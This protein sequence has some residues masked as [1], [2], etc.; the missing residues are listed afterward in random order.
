MTGSIA[1]FIA[2]AVICGISRKDIANQQQ[3]KQKKQKEKKMEQVKKVIVN[4]QELRDLGFETAANQ[5][6]VKRELARKLRIAFEHF[7]V[8]EPEQIARF[9][10]ELAKK[11]NVATTYGNT[12]Q[13]L[14]FTKVESYPNVPPVDVLEKLREAKKLNCFDTYEVAT[15]ESVVQVPD[16]VLFGVIAG[17]QNKYFIAQWDN[18]VSIEDI[19]RPEEG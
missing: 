2:T 10:Q 16:P 18:D 7:R 3:P 9:N 4:E 8:V 14:R 6:L 1:Q 17:C 15:I 19:L 5:C 12:Y 11:T 13:T